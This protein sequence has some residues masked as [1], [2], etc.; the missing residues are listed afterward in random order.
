MRAQVLVVLA[1]VHAC[2]RVCVYACMRACRHA[3]SRASVHALAASIRSM[4]GCEALSIV[5]VCLEGLEVKC[6]N[7]IFILLVYFKW[8]I[9]LEM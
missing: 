1:D 2:T 8:D 3:G 5:I 7:W 6:W 4:E 9:I